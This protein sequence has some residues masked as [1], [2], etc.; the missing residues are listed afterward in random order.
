MVEEEFELKDAIIKMVRSKLDASE[1]V[2]SKFKKI[3]KSKKLS[4]AFRS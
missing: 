4:N 3:L 2:L 1:V